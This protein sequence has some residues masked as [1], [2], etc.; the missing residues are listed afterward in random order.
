MYTAQHPQDWEYILRDCGAKVVFIEARKVAKAFEPIR[1]LLPKSVQVIAIDGPAEEPLS[2]LGR[3]ARIDREPREPVKLTPD[4]SACYIYTSGTTGR[5]KG[6]ILTHGSIVFDVKTAVSCFPITAEDRTLSFLPWAHAFGQAVDLHAM[7][8]VGC[9]VALNGDISHLL[10]NLKMVQP[11]ILIAV[12]RVFTRIHEVVRNQVVK[13]TATIQRLFHRGLAAAIRRSK[14]NTLSFVE[15]LWLQAA[16]RIVFRSV[17]AR[18]GG[19][20]RFVIS[21]SAALD[22]TVAEFIDA[23]GID[24][25]EGYGLT[26]ASPIVAV[27]H[28]QARRFGTVGKPMPGVKVTIDRSVGNDPGVGEILVNGPNVMSG[29]YRL[30]TESAACMTLDGWLRTGDLGYL[31]GDGYLVVTGRIK[32][33]Y[34]LNNGKYV[35]PTPIEEK[36]KQSPLIDNCLL[37]GADEPFNVLIVTPDRVALEKELEARGVEMTNIETQPEVYR[38]LR[39]EVAALAKE[40]ASYV[41]PKKLVIVSEGFTIENGLLTPSLKVRRNAV[42][43]KYQSRLSAA[44]YESVEERRGRR[45]SDGVRANSGLNVEC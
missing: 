30:P 22:R 28:F 24:F 17:R 37:Y 19:R 10:T 26:E 18:F 21:G 39:L 40:F 27:N 45:L 3:L 6:V 23:I 11:T 44:Y 32:E 29:Y 33:Q 15:R 2:L 4:V 31:D 20:L 14:G 12:P 35:A 1:A 38:L 42:V 25:F 9:Q 5:P 41:R 8:Y 16:D 34:K 43:E 13:K 36:L 7:V